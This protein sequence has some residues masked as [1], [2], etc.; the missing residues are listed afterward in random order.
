MRDYNEYVARAAVCEQRAKEARTRKR[1][2]KLVSN[3]GQLARNSETP[4]NVGPSRGV[5]PQGADAARVRGLAIIDTI[6]RKSIRALRPN[7]KPRKSGA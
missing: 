7:K 6:G 3:G 4:R 2:A 1:K 5:Y